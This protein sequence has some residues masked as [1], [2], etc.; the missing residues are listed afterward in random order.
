ME[1]SVRDTGCGIEPEFLPHVFDRFR[2]ADGTIARKY[3][4]LGLGLSIVKSLVELHGGR[5][6]VHSAGENQGATFTVTLP[7]MAV[8]ENDAHTLGKNVDPDSVQFIGSYA[9]GRL[10][11]RRILVVDDEPDAVDLLKTILLGTKAIVSTATSADEALFIMRQERPDVLVSD[12]GMPRKDG[13]QFIQEVRAIET[14]SGEKRLPSMSLTA[15]ARDE[16]AARAIKAGF[17]LHL[18]KPTHSA[19]L[20]ASLIQL[21]DE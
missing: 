7:G 11:G 10:A 1:L 4:G 16:D 8:V 21:L 15:F 13:Y 18:S 20:L 9:N 3:G 12:I 19:T 6:T 2:Q 5:V 17:D 14:A